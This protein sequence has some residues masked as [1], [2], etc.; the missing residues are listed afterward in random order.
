[1][2]NTTLS[3]AGKVVRAKGEV[4]KRLPEPKTDAGYRTVPL[5]KFAAHALNAPGG[6]PFVGQQ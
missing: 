6:R 4:L 5:P 1:M 3:V 2:D